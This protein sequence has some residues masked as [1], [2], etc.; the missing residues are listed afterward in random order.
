[1]GLLENNPMVTRWDKFNRTTEGILCSGSIFEV[2]ELFVNNI[3]WLEKVD[4]R[5]PLAC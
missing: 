1:M 5:I 4:R 3:E 2:G